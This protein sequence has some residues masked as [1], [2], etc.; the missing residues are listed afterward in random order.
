MEDLPLGIIQCGF[1]ELVEQP[2]LRTALRGQSAGHQTDSRRRPTPPRL[3]G[4][5]FS[6]VSN[7]PRSGE[8]SLL[9][10]FCDKSSLS[11]D[12]RSSSSM[13]KGDSRGDRRGA[14]IDTSRKVGSYR[15][16]NGENVLLFLV[17]F[18]LLNALCVATFFQPDEYFQSLEPAW[19][20]AFGKQSGAWITWV[21]SAPHIIT[22]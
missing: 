11:Y 16:Q 15:Q 8:D 9:G 18:R 4:F 20:I 21:C 22:V 3:Q 6:S 17:G 19:E 1:S 14:S 7:G 13:E 10:V 12:P 2:S 5:N